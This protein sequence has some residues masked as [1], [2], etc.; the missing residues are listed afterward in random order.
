MTRLIPMHVLMIISSLIL[1]SIVSIFSNNIA[2]LGLLCLVMLFVILINKF[3]IKSVVSIFIIFNLVPEL[4]KMNFTIGPIQIQSAEITM[5]IALFLIVLNRNKYNVIIKHKLTVYIFILLFIL[6][7]ISLYFS[8]LYLDIGPAIKIYRNVMYIVVVFYLMAATFNKRSFLYSLFIT[9]SI[10]SISTI[11]F[12]VYKVGIDNEFKLYRNAESFLVLSFSYLFFSFINKEQRFSF[13]TNIIIVVTLVLNL[14]AIVVQ[15]NRVQLI[16]VVVSVVFTLL[17]R[18]FLFKGNDQ[19]V[20][21]SIFKLIT[22]ISIITILFRLLLSLDEVFFNG[23]L[24]T[25]YENRISILFSNSGSFNPDTSLQI[26]LNQYETILSLV[27]SDP[28][29]FLFGKGL[30]AEYWDGVFIVDSFWFWVIL[31]LGIVGVAIFGALFINLFAIAFKDKQ[32]C[33][34]VIASIVSFMIMSLTTPNLIWR[35]SDSITMGVLLFVVYTVLNSVRITSE[36]K[37]II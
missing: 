2:T 13:R 23:F 4:S 17:V 35:V 22:I 15:Q 18:L 29:S 32:N 11:L 28:F 26:R 1:M 19:N 24:N 33:T 7:T 36:G 16:A 3:N 31:N 20:A 21:K 34:P 6:L 9:T 12:F 37:S 10:I 5:V 27:F 30:G 14:G 8:V 25:Y